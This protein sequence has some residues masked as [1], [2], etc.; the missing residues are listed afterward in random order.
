MKSATFNRAILR[1]SGFTLVELM[2]SLVLGLLVIGAV[3]AVFLGGSR[4]YREEERVARLHENSR[5]AAEELTHEIEMGSHWA[6]SFFPPGQVAE[7]VGN[8]IVPAAAGDCGPAGVAWRYDT[9]PGIQILDNVA[10]GGANAAAAFSCI[11]PA[12]VV[13][14]T[15]I[16]SIKRLAGS[17]TREPGDPLSRLTDGRV[18]VRTNNVK[19][20]FFRD[21]NGATAPA[22]PELTA[23]FDTQPTTDWEYR[24]AIYYIRNF[25]ITAGDGIPSLCRKLLQG[26]TVMSDTAGCIP[27]VENMQIEAGLDTN[28]DGAAN[29]YKSAPTAN[30]I[31]Y[32]DADGTALASV[33]LL[34]LART[35][36]PLNG[37]T[38]AKTYALSNF[39]NFTP[40]GA[41]TRFPREL[42]TAVV[43]VRNPTALA[44]Y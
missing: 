18:Y 22:D 24:V 30:E 34:L 23:A 13:P 36:Q 29:L 4:N 35:E 17:P 1:T 15:D 2:V 33:R 44:L 3:S 19:A 16:I 9:M 6:E 38:N 42:K 10:V 14:G 41:A 27:G 32:S 7:E 12:E 31:D 21:P 26:I 28:R 20:V 39:G 37:Y 43:L 11:D 40:A 25:Y 8:S 5:F